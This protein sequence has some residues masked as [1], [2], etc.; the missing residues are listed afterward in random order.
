MKKQEG[1]EAEDKEVLIA[2]IVD[3]V[4]MEWPW[5]KLANGFSLKYTVKHQKDILKWESVSTVTFRQGRLGLAYS[6]EKHN[7]TVH[8]N[9]EIVTLKNC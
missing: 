6:N 2:T 8:V 1:D 7:N 5:R 9:P 4:I 3:H